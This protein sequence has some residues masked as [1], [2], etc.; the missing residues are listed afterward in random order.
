MILRHPVFSPNILLMKEPNALAPSNIVTIAPASLSQSTDS[1][2][3]KIVVDAKKD[4]VEFELT[5]TGDAKPGKSEIVAVAKSKYR[6]A[7]WIKESMAVTIEVL[8]NE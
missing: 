1:A 5:A 2:P 8:K 4:F 6:G 3:S 7:A